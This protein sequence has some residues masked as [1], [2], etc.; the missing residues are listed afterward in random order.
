[1]TG[2]QDLASVAEGARGDARRAVGRYFTPLPV[3]R[4]LVRHTLAPLLAEADPDRPLRI[5][6]PACGEG[7][8]LLEAYRQLLAWHRE[9]YLIRRAA[10]RR[11]EPA[12]RLVWDARTAEWQ[13][14]PAERQR[15]LCASVFGVD[16]DAAG[17][18]ITKSLLAE[19]AAVGDEPMARTIASALAANFP[20]G[21]ALIETPVAAAPPLVPPARPLDWHAA[22]PAVLGGPQPGFDA[23]LG[24]PPYVNI[25]LLK[26]N[27][28]GSVQAYFR[29]RYRCAR[30]AYDLY[31]LFIEKAWEL[32]RPG[33][34]CGFVVPNKLAT[35][36]YARA[37]R[38]LLREHAT[39]LRVADVSPLRVFAEAAVYPYLIVWRKGAAGEQPACAVDEVATLDELFDRPASRSVRQQEL[40]AASGWQLHGTL[41]V[42]ARVPTR[43]LAGLAELHSGTTGFR[44]AAIADQLRERAAEPDRPGFA[45]VASGNVDRYRLRRGP[46]RFMH[47][48][49]QQPFLPEDTP[50]LTA[51]KRRLYQHPKLVIAGMT[52]R[53][54]A[55]WDEGGLALGVQVFAA[56]PQGE[57]P[58]YLLGLLN[59]KLLTYLFRLRF[60][61]KRLA[62]GFLAIHKSQLSL[63]P[64]RVVDGGQGPDHE[65]RDQL[66]ELVGQLQQ[67]IAR[68]GAAGG[69]PDDS[70]AHRV[71]AIEEAID[72]T[73]YRL[74]QLTEAEINAVEAM[75][76]HYCR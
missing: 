23:V 15:I 38:S 16:I 2:R 47:R 18:E 30:G 7:V 4:Y 37:C 3:V 58:R 40:D 69:A 24:N 64:I 43:P 56:V 70:V 57:D 19:A 74:Y 35:A 59:S 50:R 28:G 39:V 29:R 62:G 34:I 51:R 46:V 52:R 55:A 1:M 9:Q 65:L 54:E 14:T 8:F 41:D 21:D 12:P 26:Q 42:E 31:V 48:T 33:G 22:F 61:A 27:R 5:L 67:V 73:V 20:C 44:A 53:L 13:L 63:L 60:R 10:G 66:I 72:R 71:T 6:E 75:L 32:L 17:L 68:H 49:F 36:D 25:R 11:D 76:Q 45:F